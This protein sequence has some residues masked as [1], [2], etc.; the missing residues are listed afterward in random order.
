MLSERHKLPWAFM[1][2]FNDVVCS[3]EKMGGNGICRRRVEEYT[4]CMNY[5]N[6]FDL[7]FT[8]PK[9]LGPIR[10]TSLFNSR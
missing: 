10:E 5:C 7:G 2:D 8:G 6:L 4:G 1:W 3:E 9:L